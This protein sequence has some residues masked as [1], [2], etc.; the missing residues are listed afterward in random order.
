MCVC[1]CVCVCVTV[2]VRACVRVCVCVCVSVCPSKAIPRKLLKSVIIIKFGTVTAT[3]M[4]MH[5]VLIISTLTFIQGHTYIILKYSI[6]SESSQAMP[7]M[8][9]VKIV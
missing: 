3:D 2:S 5:H 8:S 4:I 6:I 9:A 7:I 1:V